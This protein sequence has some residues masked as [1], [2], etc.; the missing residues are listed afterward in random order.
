MAKEQTAPKT[1]YTLN[2]SG[3]SAP[4]EDKERGPFPE[5][6]SAEGSEAGPETLSDDGEREEPED[7]V[8]ETPAEGGEEPEFEDGEAEEEKDQKPETLVRE[9]RR[10]AGDAARD[11]VS[12]FAIGLSA[13]SGISP[14]AMYQRLHQKTEIVQLTEGDDDDLLDG[15]GFEALNPEILPKGDLDED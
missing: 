6:R 4:S 15:T 14:E 8:A 3:L 5:D 1:A 13:F 2:G 10:D 7:S 12:A 9:L 11:L